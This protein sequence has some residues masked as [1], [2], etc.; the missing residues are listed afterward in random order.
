MSNSNNMNVKVIYYYASEGKLM[1]AGVKKLVP[2]HL[3]FHTTD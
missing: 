2:L 3:P 1:A